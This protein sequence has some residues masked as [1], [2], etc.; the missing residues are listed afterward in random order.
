[1]SRAK[2][3]NWRGLAAR[4]L[5]KPSCLKGGSLK[6]VPPR[7]GELCPNCQRPVVHYRIRPIKSQD[8]SASNSVVQPTR[9]RRGN[10]SSAEDGGVNAL[11]AVREYLRTLSVLERK[12]CAEMCGVS[13]YTLSDYMRE[14]TRRK[15]PT[16]SVAAGIEK[17]SNGYLSKAALRPDLWGIK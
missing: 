8:G 16:P 7:P 1:M 11:S 3:C 10:G 14:N 9:R 6:G 13:L 4:G 12:R 5:Y 17:H 2:S 15:R